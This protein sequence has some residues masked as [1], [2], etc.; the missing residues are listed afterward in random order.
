MPDP[1]LEQI[2]PLG[3]LPEV[4]L[5]SSLPGAGRRIFH[6]PRRDRPVK[7]FA[8]AL[9][10]MLGD[11]LTR[12]IYAAAVKMHYANARL[13]LYYRDDRP[14]KRDLVAINPYVDQKIVVSGDRT[15][16]LDV[17][18][19]THDRADVPGTLDFIKHGLADPDIVLTP[20]MMGVEDL[21]RFDRHPI[22]RIP[23]DRVPGLSDRLVGLGLDPGRWFCCLFYRQPTYGFRGAT[24]YRDVD[25]RPFE[26]LARYIVGELGGQVVR[27][28]HPEMRP[29]DLG[30]GF[31]DLSRLKD[32][33]MVQA[34]AVSRA[35]FMVTTSSGPAHLPGAFDVPYVVTNS[36]AILG[37]WTPAGMIM[38]NH[39]VDI[40]GRRFDIREL[41]AMGV[42]D[43]GSIRHII[44]N[45]ACRL[46]ENSFEELREVSNLLWSRTTDCPGWRA[47]VIA[48][49][50]APTN[51]IDILQPYRRTVTVV[52]F[53]QYWPR[54]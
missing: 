49:T 42:L 43:W 45:R 24:A 7:I 6:K 26:A 20:S 17:F 53:P 8:A 31:V 50:P 11:F 13:A 5:V 40:T 34:M 54:A 15:T 1:H 21:L 46:V 29:F 48:P 18:N 32:E 4:E 22:F 33:F 37:V 36:L 27:L 38:P 19:A 2:D 9:D 16:A 35:R 3:C 47:P 14:Y 25:D 39:L 44:R 51:R 41:A 10:P 23:E 30:P 52:E 12:N 28:G